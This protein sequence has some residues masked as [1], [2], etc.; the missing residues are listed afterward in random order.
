V[1]LRMQVNPKNHFAISLE[2]AF[3]DFLFCHV[4]LHLVVMNFLG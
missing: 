4:I 3:A 1:A 2:R